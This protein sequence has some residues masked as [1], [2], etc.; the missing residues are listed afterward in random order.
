VH[1]IECAPHGPAWLHW[2][3]S[4]LPA[5]TR[6]R[7]W[8]QEQRESRRPLLQISCQHESRRPLLPRDRTGL[9]G[10]RLCLWYLLT[11][12]Q[13][14]QRLGIVCFSIPRQV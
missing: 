12:G 5:P 6:C 7:S 4:R 3:Y 9:E 1:C 8:Q 13:G 11:V 14:R 2:R 10:T